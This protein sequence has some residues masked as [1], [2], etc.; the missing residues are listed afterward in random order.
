MDQVAC[1]GGMDLGG[2][3]GWSRTLD[4]GR[5]V[6]PSEGMKLR[7]RKRNSDITRSY[8]NEVGHRNPNN[9]LGGHT[10]WSAKLRGESETA[11]ELL[12]K[13]EESERRES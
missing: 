7:Q 6:S 12:D 3:F 11:D 13:L 9:F 8:T 10:E 4:A 1:S 2:D 5:G